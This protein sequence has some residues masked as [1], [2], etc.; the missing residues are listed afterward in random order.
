MADATGVSRRTLESYM[1]RENPPLPGLETLGQ[2]SQGL[3]VSLDWLVMG[4]LGSMTREILSARVCAERAALPI[5]RDLIA[6]SQQDQAL[7][8]PEI[9]AT[10]I[11]IEAARNVVLLFEELATSGQLSG[12]VDHFEAQ[13]I[14]SLTVKRDGMKA[15]LEKLQAELSSKQN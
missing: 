12:L 10:E 9:I 5:I 13:T 11:G 4:G 3:G 6:K 8:I 7:L 15:E 14:A 2:I 1:R